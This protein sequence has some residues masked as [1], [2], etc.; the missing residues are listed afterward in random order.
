MIVFLTEDLN[1]NYWKDL[2]FV[3]WVLKLTRL[4]TSKPLWMGS[5]EVATKLANHA[6][7]GSKMAAWQ[8]EY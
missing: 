6:L 5:L 7:E 4:I 2:S 1:P 8:V 3:F